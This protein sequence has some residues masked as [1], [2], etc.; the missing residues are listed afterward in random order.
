MGLFDFRKKKDN[1]NTLKSPQAFYNECV[2]DFHREAESCGVAK[3]GLIFIPELMDI[4]ETAILSYLRDP[5]L[6]SEFE[7]N[8]TVLYYV[9]MSLAIESGIVFANKWHE[10]FPHLKSYAIEIITNGPADDA[11][12]LLKKHFPAN[13][14]EDQGNTFFRKIFARWVAMHKPY[15]DLDDPRNYTFKALVAAYQLGI[16]MMLEKLGY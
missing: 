2:S 7:D 10:D 16:S 4:G 12:S 6:Q 11:N 14:S 1:S 8:P 9:I 5:Y 15:W 3:K 13:V